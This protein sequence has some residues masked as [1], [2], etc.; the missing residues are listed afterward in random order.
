M[1]LSKLKRGK[2]KEASDAAEEE[3]VSAPVA[4]KTKL[5]AREDFL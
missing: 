1:D 2:D 3:P 4:P 5:M